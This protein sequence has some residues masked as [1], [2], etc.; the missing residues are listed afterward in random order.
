MNIA[1]Q[2][3]IFNQ[4]SEQEM[5]VKKVKIKDFLQFSQ[6]YI[7]KKFELINGI[8]VPM[9]D[10]MPV[11]GAIVGN[12]SGLFVNHLFS[13]HSPYYFFSKTHCKINEYHCPK[14]DLLVINNQSVDSQLLKYPMIVGEIFSSN[15]QRDFNKLAYY[16]NCP[17]VQKIVLIKQD[18]VEITL[19]QRTHQNHW[20]INHYH[21][22]EDRIYFDSIDFYLNVKDVYHKVYIQNNDLK[23]K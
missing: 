20:S 15:Q 6:S 19:Y 21:S 8:I 18:K 9:P 1:N 10:E 5:I 7:D 22:I 11:H 16:Q 12:C 4:G 13:T 2:F 23:N 17:S 3:L 14:S